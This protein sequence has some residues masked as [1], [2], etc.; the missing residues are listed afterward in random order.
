MRW[1]SLVVNSIC[2]VGALIHVTAPN[3]LA[4]PCGMVP[5]ILVGTENPIKRIGVQST[6]VFYKNGL[7]TIVLRPEYEG[8]IDE[9]G[10]LIPFPTPPAIRKV[11]DNVF[12]QIAAAIDP[13]EVTVDLRPWGGGGGFGGGGGGGGG[14]GGGGL[15]FR[16]PAKEEI[17]VIREEAIGMYEVAV[18]AAGSAAALRRWMDDHKYTYP[19]GM[20]LVCP[21]YVSLGWCFV[22]V[23]TKVNQKAASDPKPGQRAIQ[24]DL[25]AGSSFDGAVQAMGFRFP[26]RELVV[27]MRLSAFN[28]G[29]T[30]NVVYLL[31]E[32]SSKIK[33]LP[34]AFVRRQISG[35]KLREQ[36]TDPL[37]VR[38]LG[39]RADISEARVRRLA[40]DRDP[41]P[42]NGVAAELFAS[43][44]IA[45]RTRQLM[46]EHEK[47][48][49][50]LLEISEALELRGPEIDKEIRDLLDQQRLS[51]T[52]RALKSL[53]DMI[54]T[55]I[56][57]EFPRDVI[58]RENLKFVQYEMP[59]EQSTPEFYDAKQLGPAGKKEGILHVSQLPQPAGL[60]M[61]ASHLSLGERTSFRGAKR[62]NSRSDDSQ[63]ALGTDAPRRGDS[64]G[65]WFLSVLSA[66]AIGI[67]VVGR[68]RR[69]R[70]RLM[71]VLL[72]ALFCLSLGERVAAEDRTPTLP[73]LVQRLSDP[74]TAREAAEQ[75]VTLGDEA[76]AA[77]SAQSRNKDLPTSGWAIVCLGRIGGPQAT[78]QLKSICTNRKQ[79]NLVRTWAAAAMVQAARTDQ[80]LDEVALLARDFPAIGRPVAFEFR[81]RLHDGAT[82]ESIESLIGVTIRAPHLEP[83]IATD[84]LSSGNQLLLRAMLAAKDVEVR[85]KAAA[86][87]ATLGNTPEGG[88]SVGVDLAAAMQFDPMAKAPPWHDGPL[89]LPAIQWPVAESRSLVESL[90]TWRVWAD[91]HKQQ[92]VAQ[93]IDNN[94]A[95]LQLA[96][97]AGYQIPGSRT[98]EGWLESW[99]TAAG[100]AAVEKILKQ[101]P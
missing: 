58:G 88:N 1:S 14:F 36:L 23:K 62:D 15:G 83:A 31:S 25:P 38:I 101:F 71:F 61:L 20:D 76:V 95:S 52:R 47:L 46:S 82:I 12:Q 57:G 5:P 13:P 97:F 32:E 79:P 75:I 4:D 34:E 66:V 11:P 16:P 92:D 22:A 80:E 21:E 56:D 35:K 27:P 84:I 49:N 28:P 81:R 100:D 96:Q 8:N 30:R 98:A 73:V 42:H 67:A 78:E 87:L 39:A 70:A 69:R 6:Y 77:M 99:R 89:F 44:L 55:V 2:C 19:S 72:A 53:D 64:R 94:L 17:R 54:L 37:P 85:R 68:H 24:N 74:A 10:M 59:L 9:F 18:L 93:Q 29:E 48:E 86:Y 33:Q 45:A 91:R 3:A 41:T 51:T 40:G 63:P 65:V 7:E 90:I 26:S 60:E 50:R 43:D